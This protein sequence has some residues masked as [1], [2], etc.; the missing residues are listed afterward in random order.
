MGCENN[1]KNENKNE[2][3][4]LTVSNRNSNLK[5]NDIILEVK[6]VLLGEAAVGKSSLI[7]RNCKNT[8]SDT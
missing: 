7:T 4:R 6:I 1:K 8:F 5:N 3:L 2:D